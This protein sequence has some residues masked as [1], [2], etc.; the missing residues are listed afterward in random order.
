MYTYPKKGYPMR[1]G[2]IIRELRG[3]LTQAELA[4]KSGVNFTTISKI[5]KGTFT[6]KIELH[7]KIA[8]GLGVNILDLYK[9]LDKPPAPTYE[10]TQ[11]RE[12]PSSDIFYYDKG[13]VSQILV[14]GLSGRK[15][16]P[17]NLLIKTG[18]ITHLEQKPVGTDQ[19]IVVLEGTIEI[20]IDTEILKLQKGQSIY[21]DAS[22]PHIIRN[23]SKTTV[24]CLRVSSPA[25]L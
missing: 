8:K 22:K 13:V 17:E 15:M 25:T 6:G 24:K 1:I 19:L 11:I 23:I 14:K 4:K 5:E 3:N 16:L 18:K 12:N 7:Q 20:K 21:F 10:I 2:E 9:E